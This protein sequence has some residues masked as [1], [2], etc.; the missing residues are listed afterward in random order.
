M[1]GRVSAALIAVT[2]FTA[3]FQ[4]VP[5]G[6]AAAHEPVPGVYRVGVVPRYDARRNVAVWSPILDDISGRTGLKFELTGT[7][8]IPEFEKEFAQGVFDF[9]YMNPYHML[10]AEREQGYRPLVRGQRPLRGVLVVRRDSPYK[11]ARELQGQI[12]AFPSPN[13]MGASLLIR[14][15]LARQFGIRYE[16]RYV[17]THNSV[18]LNVL[19]RQ[20]AAGGGVRDTLDGQPEAVRNGLRVLYS[21]RS[22]PSHP[23]VAHRRVPKVVQ[24][25]VRQ[26]F[27]AMG[28][29]AE[30][31]ALLASASIED[32]QPATWEEYGVL[33]Q[34]DLEAFYQQEQP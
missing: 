14:A 31:R 23:F 18:Y 13:A 29:T 1:Y 12:I 32:I 34:L 9:S 10:R 27:L 15:D 17:M 2:L 7:S 28:R 21:T 33:K 30:G 19:T 8:S 16:A 25:Q 5:A 11:S 22:L 6:F 20:A 26:A 4:A 3:L 24:E